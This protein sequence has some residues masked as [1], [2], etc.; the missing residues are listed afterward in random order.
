[1][2]KKLLVE[3][4]VTAVVTVAFSWLLRLAGALTSNAVLGWGDDQIAA[5]MGIK[6][7][8]LVAVVSLL[9][10]WGPPFLL[11]VVALGVYHAWHRRWRGPV[12][13]AAPGTPAKAEDAYT[14]KAR[15]VVRQINILGARYPLMMPDHR[16]YESFGRRNNEAANERY[17]RDYHQQIAT[18][19]QI[20]LAG[21]DRRGLLKPEDRLYLNHGVAARH[22]VEEIGRIWYASSVPMIG[23]CHSERRCD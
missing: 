3:S 19:S 20:A 9:R 17:M 2:F 14:E 10:E 18:D 12:A 4:G 16:D 23:A 15:A 22:G 11:A 5:T 8:S 21:A 1:M 7:P 6:A 13:Q